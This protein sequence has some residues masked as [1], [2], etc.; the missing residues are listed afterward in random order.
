MAMTIPNRIIPALIPSQI[1]GI[2]F[3]RKIARIVD[4]IGSPSKEIA[5]KYAG[6]RPKDQLIKECP[7]TCG[8]SAS[9]KSKPNSFR[10]MVNS[11]SWEKITKTRSVTPAIE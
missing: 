10:F 4:P 8:M 11:C 1:V 6:I 5:T 3:K 9:R 2:S 7:I